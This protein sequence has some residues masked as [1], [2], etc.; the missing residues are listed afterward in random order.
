MPVE[1]L[2]AVSDA[3]LE[4]LADARDRRRH[5]RRGGPPLAGQV[6]DVQACGHGDPQTGAAIGFGA[7]DARP[8]P[9]GFRSRH[10][11]HVPSSA[12]WRKR[13]QEAEVTST[14]LPR[15]SARA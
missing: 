4:E 8:R 10:L 12:G 13:S 1:R 3:L 14:T 2:T 11:G 6:L 5:A 15:A 9:H 7:D